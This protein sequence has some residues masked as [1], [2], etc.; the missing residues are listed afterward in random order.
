[1]KSQKTKLL[2]FSHAIY[3]NS[4]L[5]DL[6]A[7]SGGLPELNERLL[8]ATTAKTI[9]IFHE[10]SIDAQREMLDKNPRSILQAFL[11]AAFVLES[12]KSVLLYVLP[13]I[14][15]I[16]VCRLKRQ[17]RIRERTPRALEG[18]PRAGPRK[19]SATNSGCEGCRFQLGNPRCCRAPDF[20]FSFGVLLG[21]E[22]CGGRTHYAELPHH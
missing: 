21:A 10:N 2:E 12:E 11:E 6:S 7:S 3:S 22:Q 5:S 13:Y 4:Q 8:G 16:L 17:P 20:G 14:D 1:M 15:A 9:K 18:R 19:I